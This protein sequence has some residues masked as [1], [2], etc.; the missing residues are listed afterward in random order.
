MCNTFMLIDTFV[1]KKDQN[2]I[3]ISSI[4]EQSY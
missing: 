1:Y 3:I 2:F 4:N